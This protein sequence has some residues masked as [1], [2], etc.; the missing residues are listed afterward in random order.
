[1]V[2]SVVVREVFED[3]LHRGNKA[4]WDKQTTCKVQ[5]VSTTTATELFNER[6]SV[7]VIWDEELPD[8]LDSQSL[9]ECVV[10]ETDSQ[11]CAATSYRNFAL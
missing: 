11:M 2:L 1:M 9:L 6:T 5:M 8:G 3:M 10:Q 4:A 7:E